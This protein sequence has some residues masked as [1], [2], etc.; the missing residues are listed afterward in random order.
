MIQIKL[1]QDSKYGKKGS[2]KDVTRN[3]A[4]DIIDQGVG[5]IF[6]RE[7][8]VYQNKMIESSSYKNPTLHL[9][10]KKRIFHK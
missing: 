8:G 1:T 10:K 2:V 5:E 9:K 3:I 4:H 7:R 6:H